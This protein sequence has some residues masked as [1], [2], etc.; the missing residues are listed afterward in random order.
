MG[1][2][3]F[4]DLGVPARRRETTHGCRDARL[5]L[6]DKRACN[7]IRRRAVGLYTAMAGSSGTGA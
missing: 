4:F 6:Y 5:R 7:Q 3:I 1:F 2:R